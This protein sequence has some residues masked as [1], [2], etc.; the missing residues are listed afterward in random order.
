MQGG[1]CVALQF[2]AFEMIQASFTSR[3]IMNAKYERKNPH[4]HFDIMEMA[5]WWTPYKQIIYL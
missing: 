1:K 5:G 3:I 4:T 2:N